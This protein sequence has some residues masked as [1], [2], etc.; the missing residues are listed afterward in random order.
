MKITIFLEMQFSPIDQTVIIIRVQLQSLVQNLDSLVV[1]Q[2]SLVS[3]G[4]DQIQT[5]FVIG[6]DFKGTI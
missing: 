6:V 2:Q 1:F 3:Q 4:N 5:F